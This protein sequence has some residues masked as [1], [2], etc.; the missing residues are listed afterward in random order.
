MTT[1]Y[2]QIN[3]A[4][5][6]NAT[7]GVFDESDNLIAE[8]ASDSRGFWSI[9]SVP[10]EV[11]T[12]QLRA[13]MRAE[14][15]RLHI[16]NLIEATVDDPDADVEIS[17]APLDH[18]LVAEMEEMEAERQERRAMRSAHEKLY[19]LVEHVVSGG[20]VN[21][22]ELS[23]VLN[24]TGCHI[25]AFW[26]EVS[27]KRQRQKFAR[28]VLTVAA[29]GTLEERDRKAVWSEFNQTEEQFAQ[30]VERAHLAAGARWGAYLSDGE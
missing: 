15:G 23:A 4:G 28:L 2:L 29:G 13:K 8:T 19:E 26:N 9:A 27:T 21:N 22:G 30:S 12:Y 17:A 10:M 5:P 20:E 14:S 1:G 18:E 6:R 16:S 7:V 25:D 11:G 3:G 24:M